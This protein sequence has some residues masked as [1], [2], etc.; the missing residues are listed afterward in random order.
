[1]RMAVDDE[2]DGRAVE[3]ELG[4]VVDD[5]LGV[6]RLARVQARVDDVDMAGARRVEHDRADLLAGVRRPEV[7]RR[8]A[9]RRRRSRDRRGGVEDPEAG[10]A[11]V[12]ELEAEAAAEAEARGARDPEDR[13]ELAVERDADADV[14]Y[15]DVDV[16]P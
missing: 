6:D 5:R 2:V 7:G 14:R 12:L 8:R 10:D 13:G 11:D 9:Q 16:D 3:A 4:V 1:R 15:R